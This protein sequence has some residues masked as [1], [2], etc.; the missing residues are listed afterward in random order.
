MPDTTITLLAGE[1]C[2]ARVSAL[3]AA[4]RQ[5]E[6]QQDAITMW[7]TDASPHAKHT[8]H[9][10]AQRAAFDVEDHEL[11]P[12]W[13]PRGTILRAVFGEHEVAIHDGV[14]VGLDAS[15]Q[16]IV[17]AQAGVPLLSI[18]RV[19]HRYATRMIRLDIR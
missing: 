1:R 4:P 6:K 11:V 10:L 2:H 7:S 19:I 14:L 9:A 5:V 13:Q 17:L 3:L 8:L 16:I 15:N 12:E 18:L